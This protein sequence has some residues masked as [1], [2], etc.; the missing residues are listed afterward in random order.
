MGGAAAFV[1]LRR[2]KAAPPYL[3]WLDAATRLRP[4]SERQGKGRVLFRAS[5]PRLLQVDDEEDKSETRH[6][7]C[8]E[9]RQTEH[10]RLDTVA[11]AQG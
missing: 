10:S 8:Y 3:L 2:A 11:D 5:L 1:P 6:L 4:V 9:D 7:G